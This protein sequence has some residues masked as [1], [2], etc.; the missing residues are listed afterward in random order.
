MYSSVFVAIGYQKW[1]DL[2]HCVY[3]I[4]K[5]TPVGQQWNQFWI[6][7][8]AH[9]IVSVPQVKYE[10]LVLFKVCFSDVQCI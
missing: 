8:I 3:F 6:N 9:R 5:N 1:Q 4:E 2:I 10:S 7:Y